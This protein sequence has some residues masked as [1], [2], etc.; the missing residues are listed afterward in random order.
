MAPAQ[1][2]AALDLLQ[3]DAQRAKLIAVLQAI[4]GAQNAA[5]APAAPAAAGAAKPAAPVVVPIPVPVLAPAPAAIPLPASP[6]AMASAAAAASLP[7][8]E[9]APNSVGAQLLF[10][11]SDKV[12]ALSKQAIDVALTVTDF[13]LLWT[14]VSRLGTNAQMQLAIFDATWRL[15]LVM[16]CGLAVEFLARRGLRGPLR[17]LRARAPAPPGRL[18]VAVQGIADAEAG[19]SEW[20]RRRA[21]VVSL[22]RR[23]P[24]VAGCFALDL[25]PVLAVLAVGYGTLGAGL[26]GGLTSRL[27]ILAVL[28]AFVLWRVVVA[29]AR[30]LA[31]PQSDLLRLIPIGDAQAEVL[32]RE[33][34]RL[35]AVAVAGYVVTETALLFG[36][37]L[38][39]HDALL[40]LNALLVYVLVVRIVLRNRRGLK[41]LLLPRDGSHG[42]F[43]AARGAFAAVWHRLIIFYLLALWTVWALDINH[44]FVRL[45]RVML[46]AVAISA[47][48][49]LLVLG[50]QQAL[51]RLERELE[52]LDETYPGLE[53]RLG[54]YLPF[55]RSLLNLIIIA[56]AMFT[57]VQAW[58]F[59]AWSWFSY[60]ALGQ[61]A[62][63]AVGTIGLTFLIALVVWELVNAAIARHLAQLARNAQLARSARLRTLLPMFRTTLLVTVSLVAGLLILSEIGVNIAPLLAGASV[64]GLAIGFGSQKLVQDIITGLFLLLENTMQVGDVVTLGG[65][66][67]T[68]ENLSIRTIRLRA[69]DGAVHI[70]PFSAVTTVT[71]NTRDYGFA[72]AD[73]GVGLNEEPDRIAAVLKE[74]AAKM[75]TESPWRGLILADLEVMGVE[76]FVDTAWVMRVRIKT[77]PASRWAVGREFNRRIKYRFD[78]LA[79]ESPMTSYRALGMAAAP[80]VTIRSSAAASSAGS[81]AAD[82]ASF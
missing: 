81:T 17:G 80:V 56:A 61:Q 62:I 64:I 8:I 67:G 2:K 54:S 46:L 11:I 57:T 13:P 75:R 15:L 1:A 70:V 72:L 42:L 53:D 22:V 32:V 9:L 29:V 60:G 23:L 66:S 26:A 10:G 21:G 16:G 78:E 43:A 77:L 50:V 52:G 30:A 3:D 35:T 27:V 6:S 58:G 74:V 24:I 55:L 14:W 73:V 5:V 12:S 47:A 51:A 45:L 69:L 40:K 34:A 82:A 76:R 36:L 37:Y 63:S 44:G 48:A 79:I 4:A 71:N 38:A 25:L 41:Q 65:M 19:E 20:M 33:V 49:R 39:A 68:V 59:D 31:S 28:N 18:P 7:A